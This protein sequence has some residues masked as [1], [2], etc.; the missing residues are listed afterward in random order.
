MTK[1]AFR[2]FVCSNNATSDNQNIIIS[3]SYMSMNLNANILGG[4]A[5][6]G[7]MKTHFQPDLKK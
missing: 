5:C 1:D 7:S 4:C 3:L 6:F 2:Y